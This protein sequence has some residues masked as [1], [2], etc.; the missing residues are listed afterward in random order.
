MEIRLRAMT[1]IWTGGLD[2]SC[3]RL[4]ETGLIGSLRWWYEAMVR[5]LGGYAC[6]PTGENGC[7]YDP[8]KK[9]PPEKQLCPACYLF[10]CTGWARKFRV[11]VSDFRDF[12][13]A[14]FQFEEPANNPTWWQSIF[15]IRQAI[16]GKLDDGSSHSPLR[17]SQSELY[18][19]FDQNILPVAPAIRNWLR[20]KWQHNLDPATTHNIFGG[21]QAA[22]PRCYSQ[23]FRTDRNK[24]DFNWCPKCR[25]SFGNMKDFA[26]YLDSLKPS[27]RQAYVR[28]LRTHYRLK[29]KD[30][31]PHHAGRLTFCP[32]FFDQ[33]D[34]EVINPHS[35]KTKAGTHP[36]Y[37]ECVPACA[38]GTF[39]LLYVPFDLIGQ[40]E[41]K[42][43]TQAAEDLKLVAEALREM[44][45]TYGFSA[46]RTSAYGT[47]EPTLANGQLTMA[48][49]EAQ[50]LSS[51]ASFDELVRVAASIAGRPAQEVGNGG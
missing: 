24:R 47:A 7:K 15:G 1:P 40:D 14:R 33:I 23:G 27:A 48:I 29:G 32:T 49:P 12:F 9:E 41:E 25:Q 35:R 3:D 36:I 30:P 8:K 6:D 11:K 50:P 17:K 26:A 18:K 22:C 2:Q 46:K 39:T 38:Q 42:V 5:G 45:L 4:H 10:G 20:Y 13:F 43:G 16:N 34:V 31:L 19:I 37:L 21:A 28:L 44:F 51:F